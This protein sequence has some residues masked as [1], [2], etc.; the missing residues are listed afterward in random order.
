MGFIVYYKQ[1]GMLVFLLFLI[2]C[3]SSELT[4]EENEITYSLILS[5]DHPK[6]GNYYLVD[7]P[8]ESIH[9]YTSVLYQID[10]PHPL[11]RIF[12]YSEDT[13]TIYHMG[14]P[15]TEP[16]VNY[17]TYSSEN[18]DGKRLVYLYQ[19]FIGDTLSVI[20]CIDEICEEIEF[21]VY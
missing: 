3:K 21:I 4:Y 5:M 15:I 20:G 12:W 11:Q 2:G 7:Y 1:I 8:N 9:S 19:P 17:S 10:P 16:I 13:F 14:F 6:E 18:G